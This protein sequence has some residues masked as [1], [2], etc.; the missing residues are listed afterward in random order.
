MCVVFC[1]SLIGCTQ[2]ATSQIS[3]FDER[4]DPSMVDYFETTDYLAYGEGELYGVKLLEC[5]KVLF[6]RIDFETSRNVYVYRIV[7]A[8]LTQEP[9][10]K[11]MIQVYPTNDLESYFYKLPT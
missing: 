9:I 8:P 10:N 3:R 7:F 2:E 4:L 1:F 11:L 5:H 6:D